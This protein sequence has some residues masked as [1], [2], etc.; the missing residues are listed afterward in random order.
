MLSKT[1]RHAIRALAVLA[2][3]PNG[4]YLGANAIA[5][6]IGA[7]PNY[8]GKLLKRFA[9]EGLVI[10]Q[11]GLNG[12]FRLGRPAADITLLEVLDPVEDLSKWSG[13]V[14]GRPTCGDENPCKLHHR[15]KGVKTQYIEMLETTTLADLRESPVAV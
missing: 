7:P 2:E 6:V 13:C 8:L 10:S 15:W 5:D 12:G 1:G 4:K 14:L 3:L 9:E 11:K